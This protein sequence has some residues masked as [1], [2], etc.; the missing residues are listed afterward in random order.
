MP[1]H[2]M[3]AGAVPI[4]APKGWDADQHGHCGV[5]HVL[6]GQ[7]NG[8]PTMTSAYRMSPA[9]LSA[10]AKGGELYLQ[11]IA[12]AHPVISMWVQPPGE[13]IAVDD[14]LSFDQDGKLV[15][16]IYIA[17]QATPFDI[18][19]EAL[20]ENLTDQAENRAAQPDIGEPDEIG[21]IFM[22]GVFNIREALEAAIAAIGAAQVEDRIQA[23]Q[24]VREI[25]VMTL[26]SIAAEAQAKAALEQAGVREIEPK[27]GYRQYEKIDQPD[28]GD[29]A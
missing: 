15:D 23:E 29:E 8:L 4:G 9:E 7:N 1:K 19:Y 12:N 21:Q 11:I 24:A 5:L 22:K 16:R 17:D 6:P 2:I 20:L 3:I 18:G 26:G 25:P 27:D 13:A 28:A 10:L 14:G